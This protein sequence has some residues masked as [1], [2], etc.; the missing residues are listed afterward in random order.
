[1]VI[2]GISANSH[3]AAITVIQ[4][5]EILFASQSER[6]SGIKNDAH[7]NGNIVEDARKYG[8]PNL[9]IW[10]ENPWSKSFRQLL[11]GQGWISNNVRN[12]LNKYNITTPFVTIGHHKSHASAGYY[13]SPYQESAVLIIDA[14]GEFDTTTIWHGK[15]NKL[16]KKL[17]IKYP[18]SLGLW[19][20]AMTQRVGLKPNEEEY[21]LMG[22]AA[23]GDPF[24]YMSMIL[25]DFFDHN[26]LLRLKHN[27]HR[28]CMWWR[29]ELVTEQDKYDI[30]AATQ[31]I[32]EI[33]FGELLQKTKELTKSD[34]LILGG[35]CAL[36]CVANNIAHEYFRNVWIMPN[37]GDAGNSLGAV[38]AYTQEHIPFTSPFLG[39]DIQGEYPVDNLI[40][41]LRSNKIVGVANGRA[42][43]GPRALGN[44]SLL[45]DP[46]GVEIK[47]KVNEI[48]RRQKFRPFAPSILQE[49]AD[50][51][52][53]M[54]TSHSP[55]MQYVMKCKRPKDFPA[56]IH[57]DGTSRVQT[58]T[59]QD[60][61][62]YHK[63]L[64]AW[65]EETG[66]PML[67]NTSLNI[68]GKPIVNDRNDAF[69]FEQKYG[70][71]V[72]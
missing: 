41:E 24:K 2:W 36:N 60:N 27:L 17:S 40:S 44:R 4:D 9:I 31:F 66:C 34:S 55:Y 22:M 58:V 33:Y 71:K 47:D 32:Y 10:Y 35:G 12:Y 13:T 16:E 62:G 57:A 50:K 67:V 23:Y 20:S 7:L 14:I 46:R 42:E 21:I 26:K 19:Y 45:A 6:Y 72:L 8:T 38:L 1:M 30:A 25:D 51:Y 64:T 56:I 52:F 68:K 65:Y 49:H 70:V 5:K 54:V 48:K 3:D 39:H 69:D 18:H 63:L 29:P 15:G 43:F 28:G 53:D 11:A 61:P 37:P 59:K